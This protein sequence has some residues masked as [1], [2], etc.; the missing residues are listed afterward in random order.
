GARALFQQLAKSMLGDKTLARRDGSFHGA[1]DEGDIVEG[2]RPARFLEKV[3][4]KWLQCLREQE[5]HAGGGPGMTVDHDVDIRAD[6]IAHCRYAAL[7]VPQG[8]IAFE[9]HC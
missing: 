4:I 7:G 1:L 9:R 8:R 6:G 3:E 2:L 5:A